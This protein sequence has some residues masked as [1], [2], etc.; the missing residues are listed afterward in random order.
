MYWERR[1]EGETECVR[2]GS[3]ETVKG[4]LYLNVVN[5]STID[6]FKHGKVWITKTWNQPKC[7]LTDEWIKKMWYLS[8]QNYHNIVNQLCCCC[9]L[10]KLCLTLCNSMNYSTSGFSVLH[11]LLEFVQTHVHWIS[12]DIQPSHRLSPPAPLTLSL[13]QWQRNRQEG[14]GSPNRGNRLQVSDI[15]N[16][17][18]KLQEETNFKCQIFF[19]LKFC[20]AMTTPASTWT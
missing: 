20:V 8:T 13:S 6:S 14:Q 15:F 19:L 11:H 2:I 16:L 1:R 3:Q 18:L 5:V 17:S 10:A 4:Y 9:S 7:P 12:D